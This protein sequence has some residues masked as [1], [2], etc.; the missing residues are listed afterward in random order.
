M[1][2][3]H[4]NSLVNYQYIVDLL[5]PCAKVN[6]CVGTAR[7]CHMEKDVCVCTYTHTRVI[8]V[9]SSVHVGV[10]T[11]HGDQSVCPYACACVFLKLI[12]N[13]V[14]WC[15]CILVLVSD[16]LRKCRNDSQLKTLNI[17][18]LLNRLLEQ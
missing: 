14:P 6:V 18:I 9:R 15:A 17:L 10:N 3:F 16:R 7:A 1:L 2:I 13:F 4:M 8:H 5:S 12:S 11:I